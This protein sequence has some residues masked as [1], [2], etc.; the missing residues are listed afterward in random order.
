L[1]QKLHVRLQK[2]S[3]EEVDHALWS[4]LFNILQSDSEGTSTKI[5]LQAMLP[6]ALHKSGSETET[7]HEIFKR[8]SVLIC[9]LGLVVNKKKMKI[10]TI[11]RTPE[12]YTRKSK[13][14]ITKVLLFLL[15]LHRAFLI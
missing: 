7:S 10:R 9:L 3:L 2:I 15:T 1:Q 13:L 14:D 6:E 11:S 4:F 8:F 12:D 5:K